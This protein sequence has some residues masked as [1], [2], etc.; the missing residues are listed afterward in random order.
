ML[1]T[2]YFE[3]LHLLIRQGMEVIVGLG[4]NDLRINIQRLLYI[5]NVQDHFNVNWFDGIGVSKD[6][7]KIYDG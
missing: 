4:L 2:D 3:D 1:R 7:R 6:L 5:V